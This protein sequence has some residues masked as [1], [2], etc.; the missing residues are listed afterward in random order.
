VSARP[1]SPGP[2][3]PWRI[4]S[5]GAY[6]AYV[7]HPFG[8]RAAT[9]IARRLAIDAGVLTLPGSYFGG[10]SQ[11]RH[12]RFAFAN[13]DAATIATLPARLARIEQSP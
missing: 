10:R 1:R 4:E 12:L 5:L 3:P 2:F 11:D 6:F 13:A 9:E 7:R 8:D